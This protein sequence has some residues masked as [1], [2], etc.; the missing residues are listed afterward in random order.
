MSL[1]SYRA[2]PSRVRH[3]RPFRAAILSIAMR[4]LDFLRRAPGRPGS[5]LL[6]HALRHSTIGPGG[7]NYRVRDGIGWGPPGIATRS[8]RR[9][10]NLPS[11][12]ESDIV[13]CVQNSMRISD[14]I[15]AVHERR[16]FKPI[17]LL[18]PVSF[19]PHGS[20]T[21]GLSTSWSTTAL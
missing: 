7:L 12:E 2:A 14:A 16:S 13:R 17:E 4:V 19:K 20:S 15:V 5:D 10:L 18:V 1:T 6:S 3:R 21:P 9:A 11:C 8:A